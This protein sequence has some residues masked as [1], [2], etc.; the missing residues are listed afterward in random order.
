[1]TMKTSSLDAAMRDMAEAEV[2]DLFTAKGDC[3][4][5]GECCSRFLPMSYFDIN[6]LVSYVR[7]HGIE[8]R[9]PRG[10]AG[11]IDLTCPY[12][13]D[14]CECMVYEARPEICRIYRCDKHLAGTMSAPAFMGS[15]R[16]ADLRELQKVKVL[17]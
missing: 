11:D 12:L 3:R 1:M 15:M 4:G 9:A 7:E 13:D 10:R 5:C 17:L 16:I 2:V 8:Q 6:R 14:S